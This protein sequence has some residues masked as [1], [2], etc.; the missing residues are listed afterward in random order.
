MDLKSVSATEATKKKISFEDY[1]LVPE[2]N[3]PY[4]IIDG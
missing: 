1:L 3:H 2:I 4:E